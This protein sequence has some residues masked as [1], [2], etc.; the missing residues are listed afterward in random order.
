MHCGLMDHLSSPC[1]MQYRPKTVK[2]IWIP[3]DASP[4][5]SGPIWVLSYRCASMLRNMTAHGI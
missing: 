1:R 4:N 2:Q 5:E 3:K